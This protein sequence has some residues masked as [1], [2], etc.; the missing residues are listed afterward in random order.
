[1][2]LRAG[3]TLAACGGL[4]LA[5][6]GGPPDARAQAS[7][8]AAEVPA[9]GDSALTAEFPP[10]LRELPAAG[11]GDILFYL[12]AVPFR[13]EDGG[14]RIEFNLSIPNDQLN[15]EETDG[16]FAGRVRV[17]LELL[18]EE[19]S[20]VAVREAT[21]PLSA[22]AERQV[23]DRQVLQLLT[24]SV[25]VPPGDYVA[26][27]EVL[28]VTE[29]KRGLWYRLRKIHRAGRAA[30]ALEVPDYGGEGFSLSGIEFARSLGSPQGEG[31]FNKGGLDV[32]PN[33][34]RL[35][36]VLLP[37]LVAYLEVYAPPDAAPP[38]G[39]WVTRFRVLAEDGRPVAEDARAGVQEAASFWAKTVSV[40]LTRLPAGHYQLAVS[41]EDGQGT[42]LAATRGDFQLA[43]SLYSWGRE[44]SE[45]LREMEV[46]LSAREFARFKEMSRPESERFLAAFWDE[47][48]PTPETAANEA[49]L[50][51]FRRIALVRR[52][53]ATPNSD[54]VS[55]D[56]GRLYLRYGEPDEVQEGF[57]DSFVL[58]PGDRTP[59]FLSE[60]GT[61]GSTADTQTDRLLDRKSHEGLERALAASRG[62][63]EGKRY[64]VWT[65]DSRSGNLNSRDR[66]VDRSPRMRFVFLDQDGYGDLRLVYSSEPSEF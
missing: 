28:D 14:S 62:A 9:P 48:D 58:S 36:G 35:Y 56:R 23:S 22:G 59:S 21:Y 49:L 47:R 10:A 8:P 51:H 2:V 39:G 42:V 12:D 37:E 18:D 54:G 11:Q 63:A 3:K 7:P 17:R 61:P 46:I 32:V 27:A 52:R 45:M 4:T 34:P 43:W 29:Y 40:N 31:P 41:L 55:T 50:E 13:A 30:C 16:D 53:Y 19:G 1:M 26:R 6:W 33:P 5:L 57:D 20:L 66:G 15:F 24:E 60:L 44:P 64:E 65:Y 38:E 25:P